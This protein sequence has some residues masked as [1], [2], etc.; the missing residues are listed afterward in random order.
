MSDRGVRIQITGI[1]Q[2]VGFRPFVYNL[3]RQYGITGWVSNNATGVTI[4]AEGNPAALTG[5]VKDITRQAPPLAAIDS[6]TVKECRLQGYTDFQIRASV[7]GSVKTVLISP[8]VATCPRCR[9]EL[10]NPADR[11][12][13]YPFINCTD[14]GPRF[15]IIK[16]I[17]YDRPLTTM[18]NF[19]MCPACQ[20]E[21]DNPAD[22]RFHAQPNA[23]PDCGPVYRL[24]DKAGTPV[25]AGQDVFDLARE[26]IAAGRILAIKGI[27]GYHL[28]V[29]A[30]DQSA[31]A[32][33]RAR[34]VRED[35]PFAVMAGSLAIC[36][37]QCAVSAVEEQLL[38]SPARPIVLLTKNEGYN[39]ADSIAPG[40][41]CLGVMLPYAPAHILLL[42]PANMWVMTSGNVSDEPIAYQDEDAL[43]RLGAIADY[44]LVHNREIY[45]RAD[46]SV[47]RVVFN[48]PYY[49][50]RS[51][52]YVPAPVSLARELPSVLAVGGE[53][54][55][56]FCLTR[57]R[58]AF[59][60]AHIGDL[61]NMP[62]YQSYVAA[63]AHLQKLL[64]IE[65]QVV[66]CDQHPEYLSTK[67]AQE[68]GLPIVSVQHHHAHI[69]AVMAEHQLTG[70]V[71]GLAFDGTGYGPDGALWGGEFLV[72]DLREYRR[73]GH[74]AYLPLPGG[75]QAVRQP[76]RI[77]VCLLKELYGES[78]L[79]HALPLTAQLPA[80]W[81]LV[82]TA[83][84]KKINTPRAS[85]AGR[86]FDAAAALLGIRQSIHYEGQAAIE[87]EM[88]AQGRVGRILAYDL[89]AVAGTWILD[90]KPVFAGLCQAM[91]QG[92]AVPQLAADFH[93]TLAAAACELT[94]KISKA[95]GI[96]EIVLSGGVFQ[97]M[98]L[99]T[100]VIRMLAQHKL[101]PYLHR[102]TPPNDGGLALG[103]AV[104]A[105][106]RSR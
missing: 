26:Q 72:A 39:L 53:L 96:K 9:E 44:F 11:R 40:N 14:C 51:R 71:I 33:L 8:D 100:Q 65:P 58:Q 3:A 103:Q 77:A 23:C 82:V 75:A 38:T 48:K 88:A 21:Y 55:N 104:I 22:R 101:V 47:V 95:T 2:G 78:F 5:F 37:S 43:A 97:N 18:R 90:F 73:A 15:T 13:R 49:L 79:D 93:T 87:L 99:L 84:E 27:G 31:V 83:A 81:Q 59:L 35:K 63:I 41:P 86:L 45:C 1:V 7:A 19:A 12:Y 74:L 54:K 4:A 92:A 10:L 32:R 105:G 25:E 34:K 80:N 70:P 66:A 69:A 102:Q 30:R 76:W 89:T 16:D 91:E 56:T 24:L 46:D 50:R 61:E 67:F 17:P 64:A 98:T 52:G 85:G 29:N 68:T 106:E 60:S 28:A 42:A 6:L 20:A 36:K 94:R 57:G 62:T